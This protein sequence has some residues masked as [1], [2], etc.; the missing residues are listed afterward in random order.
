MRIVGLIIRYELLID[1]ACLMLVGA[2]E[3]KGLELEGPERNHL[4]R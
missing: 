4:F 1:G 2:E 3:D